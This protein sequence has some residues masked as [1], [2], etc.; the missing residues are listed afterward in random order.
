M[1][2]TTKQWLSGFVFGTWATSFVFFVISMLLTGCDDVTVLNQH[3]IPGS[4]LCAPCDGVG[5]FM[6]F[7]LPFQESDFTDLGVCVDQPD[8][9]ACW[10]DCPEGTNH[11]DGELVCEAYR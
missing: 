8:A 2:G 4:F 11:L 3:P 9:T 10:F 7:D 5:P 6:A 1:K